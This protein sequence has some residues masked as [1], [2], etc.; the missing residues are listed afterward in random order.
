MW[1][2]HDFGDGPVIHGKKTVL[3]VAW[4]AWS[5]FKIVIALRDRTAPSV[6]AALDR[7]F[8]VWAE[9]RPTS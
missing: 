1:L 3:F 6:F 9:P 7:S 8:R 2:Q 5:R 4:L